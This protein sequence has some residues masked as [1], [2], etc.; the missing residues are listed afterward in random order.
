MDGVWR[1]DMR[2]PGVKS[3]RYVKMLFDALTGA[4]WSQFWRFEESQ[5]GGWI[6]N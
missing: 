2:E 4:M 1:T 6:K 3:R 5:F